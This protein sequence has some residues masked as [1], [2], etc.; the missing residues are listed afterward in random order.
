MSLPIP[1]LAL[2]IASSIRPKHV[3]HRREELR[4]V[5]TIAMLPTTSG[6]AL[7]S[8]AHGRSEGVLPST[9]PMLETRIHS[10]LDDGA[11]GT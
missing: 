9:P 4:G 7:S 2:K 10:T 1:K 8:R 6:E 11:N 5:P 3:G